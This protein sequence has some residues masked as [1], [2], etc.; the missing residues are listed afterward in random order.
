[1]VCFKLQKINIRHPCAWKWWTKMNVFQLQSYF[2]ITKSNGLCKVLYNAHFLFGYKHWNIMPIIL[3]AIHIFL[4]VFF[5]V[6]HFQQTLM[7]CNKMSA[8]YEGHQDV[9]V[10]SSEGIRKG[11]HSYSAGCKIIAAFSLW[12]VYWIVCFINAIIV[13]LI[14]NTQ[15]QS[16]QVKNPVTLIWTI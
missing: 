7:Y 12:S 3:Q 9:L 8:G 6:V 14:E 5:N 11:I 13:F 2:W 4:F 15:C 1:M 10:T 16:T